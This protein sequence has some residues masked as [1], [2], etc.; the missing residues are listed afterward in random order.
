M[1]LHEIRE[2]YMNLRVSFEIVVWMCSSTVM[3]SELA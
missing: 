3:A 1:N 2:Q